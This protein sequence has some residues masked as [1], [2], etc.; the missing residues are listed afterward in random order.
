MVAWFALLFCACS[1][2]APPQSPTI[3][4]PPMARIEVVSDRY[5]GEVVADPY[6][7]L[8]DGDAPEVKAWSASQN[9]HA[10]ERLSALP[11]RDALRADLAAILGQTRVTHHSVA[12]AGSRTFAM[13][14][15]PPRQQEFLVELTSLSAADPGRT[16]VDP[17]VIDPTGLTTIDWFVPSPDGQMVA[18]SLSHSGTESG[19]LH[20][21][22]VA[23]GERIE[24]PI[25]RVNG[26]TAGGALAWA[27]DGGSLFYTRYPREGERP[28]EDHDF[29]VHLYHHELGADPATDR[30][31]LGRE[32]TRIAEIDLEMHPTTGRLLVTVQDGDGGDFA[33]WIRD[34]DGT[35]RSLSRFDDRTVMMTH[36]ESG[37]HLYAVSF[38]PTPRGR[39]LRFPVTAPGIDGAETVLPQGEDTVVVSFWSPPSI[40][41][42]GGRLFVTF[43][44]GGPS[45]I[46]AFDLSGA[47]LEAPEQYPVGAAGGMR[48][49]PEGHLLYTARSFVQS[50]TWFRYDPEAGTSEVVPLNEPP[51]VDL[52]DVVVRREFATS[53]DGTKIP[54][55]L[56]IPGDRP[57]DG[58]NALIATGY[59]GYGVNRSPRFSSSYVPLLKRGVIIAVANLRGGGEYGEQWHK[60]GNLTHKQ[61]VFD[62]FHGV[63]D[64]VVE[65][66]YTSPERL[67]IMGGSNGGLLMGATF[68]QHPE[69]VAAVMSSVGIYDMLRV[70]LSPNGAFNVTEFG[71]VADPE[72]YAALRA[73]SPYH[74]VVDGADYPPILFTTG[75]ND[76][77]VDP[78]HSRKMT[79]R[80]KGAGAIEVLLRVDQNAG[81]GASTPLRAKIDELADEYSFL[82]H[83]LKVP[84]PE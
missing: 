50:P 83:H 29:Y 66:G 51:A 21:F 37:A 39:V 77:R 78:M 25:P 52:S 38:D 43:Q 62:D 55:N 61:N 65:R 26:G 5:H 14:R 16:L 42:V 64:H 54:V 44:T 1:S 15:Q 35:V 33:H 20:I 79:A 45:E 59:G 34:A 48:V 28:P 74:N 81:H 32:L 13:R 30:Y 46:R 63:L 19:D 23:T 60:Q 2:P 22:D 47:P 84:A 27:P 6:R 12:F 73:Y 41:E 70:E 4:E 7:W 80:L 57:L 8:E 9:V 49:T 17:M 24:A 31:V 72:Q 18:V 71:T 67:G 76:P 36:S 75:A 11:G 69:S 68:V 40:R 3:P 56:I 82:L 58:S 53:K 10:R